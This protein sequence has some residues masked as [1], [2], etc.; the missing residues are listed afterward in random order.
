MPASDPI[1]DAASGALTGARIGD[2]LA[3]AM[4][5][6]RRDRRRGA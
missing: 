3:R 2:D 1:L 6:W 4:R 5:D